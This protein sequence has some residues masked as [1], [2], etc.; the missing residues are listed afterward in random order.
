M[1]KEEAAVLL[2][3]AAEIC[4]TRHAGQRDKSGTAYFL[5]PMRVAMRCATDEERIVAMLHDTVEDTGLTPDDLLAQ[6]FPDDIVDAVMSV[7]KRPGE[8]YE[9]FVARAAANPVGRIVKLRDIED[10]LDALRL[11]SI[12]DTMAAR[13]NKY[14]RAHRFLLAADSST[15][16]PETKPVKTKS[17]YL[18]ER[19][20]EINRRLASRRKAGS[21]TAYM[22]E[23]IM[24][25]M[26]DGSIISERFT[27]DS[28]IRVVQH[29]GY[30]TVAA[31]DIMHFGRYPL[32]SASP[33]GRKY[34]E[35]TM[36]WHVLSDCPT[37]LI[38]RYI[39]DIAD[40]LNLNIVAD[41]CAK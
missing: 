6:G 15:A 22:Q 21:G 7:T 17:E 18:R 11:D 36:G 26:P 40:T 29:I 8:D 25:T 39:N 14:L 13:F 3:K 23:K 16:V 30:D 38:A 24:V 20:A 32:L 41:V 31:L 28:F 1:T 2:E 4:V 19:R 37:P 27:I 9:S 10:N 34:K 35:A 12:D 5:H 33:V